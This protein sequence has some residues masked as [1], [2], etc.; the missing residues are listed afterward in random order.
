MS[1]RG[2]LDALVQQELAR[3]GVSSRP[4]AKLSRKQVR[5]V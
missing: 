1:D 4:S 2:V 5:T 3:R